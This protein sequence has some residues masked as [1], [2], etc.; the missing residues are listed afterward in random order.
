M[1][2]FEL[3]DLANRWKK[4]SM[5]IKIYENILKRIVKYIICGVFIFAGLAKLIDPTAFM[6]TIEHFINLQYSFLRN[7]T[8]LIASIEILIGL[9]LFIKPT[10]FVLNIVI[11]ILSIFCI[12]LAWQ[13]ITFSPL[14]CGCFGSI[15]QVTN[16]QQLLNDIAL[17]MG[18][19]YLY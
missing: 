1:H 12:F 2:L 17:L 11:G 14:G 15:I 13:I 6:T 9:F 7:I 5:N 3:Q 16:K 4:I 8:I 19:I 18:T 10:K